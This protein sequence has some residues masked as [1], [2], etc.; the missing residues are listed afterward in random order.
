MRVGRGGQAGAGQ[1]GRQ[2]LVGL[3]GWEGGMVG[4]VVLEGRDRVGDAGG[5]RVRGGLPQPDRAQQGQQ[6]LV[7]SGI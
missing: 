5:D 4:L 2:G 1:A 3:A 7:R 6:M